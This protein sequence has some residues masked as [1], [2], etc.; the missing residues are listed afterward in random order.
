[1]HAT[2][3]VT[4]VYASVITSSIELSYM[5]SVLSGKIEESSW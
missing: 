2:T 1:M 4:M 3:A 5:S